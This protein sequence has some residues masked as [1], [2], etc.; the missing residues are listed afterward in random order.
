MPTDEIM[1]SPRKC[2]QVFDR[3]RAA[4][5]QIEPNCSHAFFVINQSIIYIALW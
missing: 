4:A 2:L 5:L 3:L 1:D